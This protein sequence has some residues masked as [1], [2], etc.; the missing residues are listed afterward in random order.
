MG[1]HYYISRISYQICI[2]I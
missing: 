1:D 2:R